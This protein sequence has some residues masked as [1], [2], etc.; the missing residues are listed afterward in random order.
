MKYAIVWTPVAEHDLTSLWL[1]SR[2][3]HLITEST[4]RIDKLL[5][6]NAHTIG[7]SR[8]ANRRIVI[9]SPLVAEFEID[10]TERTVYVRAVWQHPKGPRT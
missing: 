3:R 7:E 10:D 8:D 6:E 4:D 5:S 9:M 2:W 1:A